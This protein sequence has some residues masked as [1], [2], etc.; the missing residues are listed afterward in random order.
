[1]KFLG[2]HRLLARTIQ[3]GHDDFSFIMAFTRSTCRVILY[4]RRLQLGLVARSF[5]SEPFQLSSCDVVKCQQSGASWLVVIFFLDQS[6]LLSRHEL[7]VS[8]LVVELIIKSHV[9]MNQILFVGKKPKNSIATIALI[10]SQ[11]IN[12]QFIWNI[13]VNVYLNSPMVD[14]PIFEIVNFVSRLP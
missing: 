2:F 10:F 14:G 12:S 6:E 7:F 9:Q 11:R 1:M 8:I 5:S 3:F 4:N 13:L